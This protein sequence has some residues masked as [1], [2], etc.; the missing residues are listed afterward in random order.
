MVHFMVGITL[1]TVA[2]E[3]VLRAGR[4]PGPGVLMVTPSVRRLAS[5]MLAVLV[6]AVTCWAQLRLVDYSLP[7][8]SVAH[9]P[10][11]YPLIAL[12]T[13]WC[14][15]TVAIAACAQRSRYANLG[16]AIAAAISFAAITLSWFLPATGKWLNEPPEPPATMHGVTIT[17]YAIAAAALVVTCV[18]MRDQWYRYA[19]V[20]RRS[21][22]G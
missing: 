19:R 15:V 18:A 2:V 7:A 9:A 3:L 22:S 10:A 5:S 13:G 21:H 1:L 20:L 4:A 8:G 11:V 6:L 14:A 12:L 16:G 17:W